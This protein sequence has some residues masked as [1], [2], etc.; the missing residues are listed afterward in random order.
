[1]AGP[2]PSS[3]PGGSPITRRRWCST[4]RWRRWA[5]PPSPDTDAGAS[6]A[7]RA[8]P[9]PAPSI[10]TGTVGPHLHRAAHHARRPQFAEALPRSAW[11]TRQVVVY[12]AQGVYSSARAWWSCRLWAST[13]GRPRRRPARAGRRPAVGSGGP[14][15]TARAAPSPPAPRPRARGRRCRRRRPRRPGAAVLDARPR[16]GTRHRARASPGPARGPHAGC[17]Q[18]PLRG[19]A[20]PRRHDEGRGA[21]LRAALAAEGIDP[22]R[23][24][25]TTCGR[26]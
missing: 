5:Q 4:P 2:P 7:R 24:V 1:M 6:S 25:I 15:T 21:A 16:S 23:P 26:A 13:G 9:G 14:P 18:P 19:G 12:D 3:R 8:S 20:E 22:A 10:S 11:T 17:R